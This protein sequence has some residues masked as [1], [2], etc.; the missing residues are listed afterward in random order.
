MLQNKIIGYELIVTS[1]EQLRPTRAATPTPCHGMFSGL[2]F[3][4][5]CGVW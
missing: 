5:N 2:A 4:V 3:S 1:E